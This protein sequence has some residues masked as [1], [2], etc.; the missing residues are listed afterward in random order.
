MLTEPLQKMT[1]DAD[2]RE[3]VGCFLKI[4]PIFE[5]FL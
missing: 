2:S 1:A 3:C 4:I 5:G